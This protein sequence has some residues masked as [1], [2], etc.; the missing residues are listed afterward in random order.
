MPSIINSPTSIPPLCITET[1]GWAGLGKKLRS[2]K[3]HA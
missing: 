2:S 1:K 3:K